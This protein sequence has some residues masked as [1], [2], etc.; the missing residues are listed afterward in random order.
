MGIILIIEEIILFSG[1]TIDANIIK[2][3]TSE[4]IIQSL[5]IGSVFLL[6]GYFLP[7]TEEVEYTKCPNCKETYFILK[8]KNG[9][10]PE[11]N[12]KTI[13]IDEYYK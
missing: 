3:P 12:I 8:L 9:I 10:C 7:K 6:L 1:F 5:S 11:C 13:E 2:K 4:N